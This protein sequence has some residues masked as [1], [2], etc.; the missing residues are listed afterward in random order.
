M[1]LPEQTNIYGYLQRP[2]L[3]DFP[4][5]IA[6]VL[7]TTGCNFSCGYCHN[8]PLMGK[9]EAGLTSDELTRAVIRF[10]QHDWIDGVTISGGE[11]TLVEHLPA[12]VM[13]L[14][15]QGLKVKLDTNGSNPDMLETLL[16]TLDYVAMDIKCALSSYPEFVSYHHTDR[17]ER[18][19]ALLKTWDKPYEFRT[20]ILDSFHTDEQMRGIGELIRGA[21]Q[22]TLQ[23]FVPRDNLPDPAMRT[24]KRTSPDL[25]QQFAKDMQPY[26]DK[27]V[28]KGRQ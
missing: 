5:H 20:T 8:A 12:L 16:D 13:W 27:V 15:E 22:Y 18:S 7:F 21:Y 19:A 17:I 4:G 24:M 11:P 23:P 1:R 25:L 3:V 2:S 9:R 14:K 28:I 6:A 26:A 10:K